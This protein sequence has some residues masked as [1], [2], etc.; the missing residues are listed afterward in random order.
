MRMKLHYSLIHKVML[1]LVIWTIDY[2][3]IKAFSS[4]LETDSKCL[5]YVEDMWRKIKIT[6]VQ[7]FNNHIKEAN[8]NINFTS[9]LMSWP[10]FSVQYMLKLT[11]SSILKCTLL[12]FVVIVRGRALWSVSSH[13]G[14]QAVAAESSIPILFAISIFQGLIYCK[15]STLL[16]GHQPVLNCDSGAMS[17]Y[18]FPLFC[19]WTKDFTILCSSV[20]NITWFYSTFMSLLV[21]KCKVWQGGLHAALG[22]LPRQFHISHIQQHKKSES[23][24]TPLTMQMITHYQ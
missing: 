11:E 22:W 17:P 10:F 4:C 15:M 18:T 12:V 8:H 16:R 5:R 20:W 9:E 13:R 7:A 24:H 1:E 14:H 23:I 2:R 3:Q 21:P 19:T 6:K